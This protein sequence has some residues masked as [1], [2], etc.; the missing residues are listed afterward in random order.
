MVIRLSWGMAGNSFLSLGCPHCSNF[1]TLSLLTLSQMLI[2][3][4]ISYAFPPS[5]PHISSIFK[6]HSPPISAFLF[7]PPLVQLY[8]SHSLSKHHLFFICISIIFP[9]RIC[10][11]LKSVWNRQKRLTDQQPSEQD[12]EATSPKN[13]CCTVLHT[14]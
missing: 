13:I 2:L 7:I 8:I 3:S 6:A 12:T 11:A 4:L 1:S 9:N 5:I 10:G 14:Y